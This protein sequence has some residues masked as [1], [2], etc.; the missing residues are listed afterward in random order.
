M[1]IDF[2]HG[3]TYVT[4][5]AAGFEHPEAEKIAYC[6]QYVDDA[7]KTGTIGF[8]NKAIYARVC[9]A[10]SMM[11]YRNMEALA[12]HRVWIPFHFLPGNDRKQAWENPGQK[13]TEKVICRKNSPVAKDM[14][15]AC[16]RDRDKPF[17]LHRLGITMHVYADTWAHRGFAGINNEV[18]DISDLENLSDDKYETQEHLCG[19]FG[20]LF[21][22]VKSKFVGDALPLGHGAALCFPDLPYLEW[23]YT[24]SKGKP[25]KRNNTLDFLDA[26]D[27]LCRAMEQFR[28]GSVEAPTIGLSEEYKGKIK[29][30]FT[31]FTNEEG[32]ERHQ[33]WMERIREGF[34]PFGPG[35]PAYDPC[36]KRSWKYLSLGTTKD[37]QEY[38]WNSTF[39]NS[40]WKFFHDAL[41]D[42]RFTLLHEILPKYGICA[43]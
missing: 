8:Q 22:R 27:H 38:N 14:I 35:N 42:H 37:F 20:K 28:A 6:A 21:D 13:F 3:V 36:G 25:V 16:I 12:N 40:D 30:I 24:D 1:Q 5:R 34:F 10:H 4:A 17:A 9:S 15:A 19:F 41:L 31:T 23:Q 29:E 2:H 32:E 33:G 18:N 26:A 11:D 39:L 43:A 7:V